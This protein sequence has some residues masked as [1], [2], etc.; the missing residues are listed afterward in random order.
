[1]TAETRH[2]AGH[3]R[4]CNQG[5]F[6]RETDGSPFFWLADTAWELFH[7]LTEDEV[8]HYFTVRA[9]QG[10]NVV[11]AVILAELD[12]LHAADAGG[13]LPLVDDDPMRPNDDYFRWVDRVVELARDAGLRLALLP[14]WG[15]KVH[16]GMWGVGPVVFNPTNAQAFGRY[17]G[18]RYRQASHIVWVLGGDRPAAPDAAVWD[19]MAAGLREGLQRE[20]LMTYHPNA[21]HSSSDALH[22]RAWLSI[23]TMQ[24]GHSFTDAPSWRQITRDLARRPAKPTLDAEPCYEHHP[25]DPFSR[26]WRPEHGR[27]TDHDVRK[28]AY[29]AVFA[30]ACGHTYG[31]HSVWQFWTPQREPV[32]HP[33]PDW[34]AAMHGPGA[35]QMVWLKRLM[36]SRPYFDRVPAPELLPDVRD[37]T[38]D[39]WPT[40][41]DAD[42]DRAHRP[43]ATRDAQGRFAM[44]YV[45]TAGQELRVTVQ[46]PCG[47]AIAR[48][49]D[50]RNGTSHDAGRWGDGTHV[51]RSPRAGPDWVLVLDDAAAGFGPPATAD[52]ATAG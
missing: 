44:V 50:P 6:L 48:W 35:Q 13:R 10:F 12:G 26:A 19:A 7:R 41:G 22:G 29:R 28:V 49:F 46:T 38:R 20:T 8:R 25:I 18:E 37:D 40:P 14:T 43:V 4:V 17:L 3:L 45:P 27:F 42:P 33:A 5:R 39:P 36:L 15:D 2:T 30:G 47:E 24:S 9:G 1:M 11:Q 16:D 23:N 34:R 32:N 52:S 21:P 31:S 51:F